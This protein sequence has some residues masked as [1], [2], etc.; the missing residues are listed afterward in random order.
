MAHHSPVDMDGPCWIQIWAP[1]HPLQARAEPER[2][3]SLAAARKAALGYLAFED[4]GTKVRIFDRED[5][6]REE[7]SW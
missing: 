2:L 3:A 6:L 7:V 4:A 1:D 5:R